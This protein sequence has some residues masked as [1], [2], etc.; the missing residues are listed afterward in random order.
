MFSITTLFFF[1]L[2]IDKM[3]VNVFI[4][5]V[6]ILKNCM[7]FF[8]FTTDLY[9][10]KRAILNPKLRIIFIRQLLKQTHIYF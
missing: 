10:F 3:D 5:I 1:F 9:G 4:C 7:Y 6:S 8:F 2:Y